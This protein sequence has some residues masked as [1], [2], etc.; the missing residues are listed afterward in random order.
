MPPAKRARKPKAFDDY[1]EEWPASERRAPTLSRRHGVKESAVRVQAL[2]QTAP[3]TLDGAAI[4]AAIDADGLGALSQDDYGRCGGMLSGRLG[5]NRFITD[6]TKGLR[7]RCKHHRCARPFNVGELRLGKIPPR[8]RQTPNA[9]RVHWFHPAC[10]FKAFERAS[11]K[12][13]TLDS[14][15]EVEGLDQLAAEDRA[16]IV[17]HVDAWNERRQSIPRDAS[18]KRGGRFAGL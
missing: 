2:V 17:A 13:K 15:D 14:V 5:P 9:R 3:Q 4:C 8:A 6:Y 16:A 18:R 1:E 11:S 12:S 7:S 10:L